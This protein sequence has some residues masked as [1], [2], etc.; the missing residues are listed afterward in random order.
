VI[1]TNAVLD[2]LLLSAVVH[3]EQQSHNI[4]AITKRLGINVVGRHTAVGDALTT[5]EMFLKLIPLLEEMGIHTLKQAME[6][7]KKTYYARIEY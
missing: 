1:F 5:A 6:A 7:S 4:E 3:P 2:T